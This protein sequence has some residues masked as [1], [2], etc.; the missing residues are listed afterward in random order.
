VV[1]VT[2][3]LLA[4]AGCDLPGGDDRPLFDPCPTAFL[5]DGE[6][7]EPDVCAIGSD[8]A[9]CGSGDV[10]PAV[11]AACEIPNYPNTSGEVLQ[12]LMLSWCQQRNL[13]VRSQALAAEGAW[14]SYKAGELDLAEAAQRIE[15]Y[16]SILNAFERQRGPQDGASCVCQDAAWWA[17]IEAAGG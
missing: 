13:Q 5:N 3:L 8:A 17:Q 12:Q 7:D 2:G 10:G 6:C 4:V 15:A 11:G 16:C 9:D 1:A 14:C